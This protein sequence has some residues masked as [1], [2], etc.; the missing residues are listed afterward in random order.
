MGRRGPGTSTYEHPIDGDTP[1]V[2]AT[3]THTY[4]EPGTYFASFRAGGDRDGAN[5]LVPTENVA[6]VRVVVRPKSASS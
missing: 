6:R 5:G 4:D 2:E 3:V 1:S